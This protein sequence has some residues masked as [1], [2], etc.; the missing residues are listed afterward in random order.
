MWKCFLT[1][2]VADANT[3]TKNNLTFA[4][5]FNVETNMQENKEYKDESTSSFTDHN[6]SLE[7]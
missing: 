4:S 2:P 3:R 1:N 5:E 6:Y 7:V